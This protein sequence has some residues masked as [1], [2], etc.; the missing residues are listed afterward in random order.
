M[1]PSDMKKKDYWKAGA[2]LMVGLAVLS[3][4]M[5]VLGGLWFW[6]DLVPYYVRF[7][8]VKDLSTG[9]PVKYG[10]LDIGRVQDIKVDAKDP[11][12]IKV[13]LG[14]AADFPIYQGAVASISQKGLV[15]DYYVF[16]ELEDK[17][18]P[19][20]KPGAEIP[21][22]EGMSIQELA[23][24]AGELMAEIKPKIDEIVTNVNKVFSGEN[25]KNLS[26][27]LQKGPGFI[28]ETEKAIL[29]IQQDW[30]RLVREGVGVTDSLNAT[31]AGVDK[32]LG[33]VETELNATL[34]EIRKETEKA[35]RLTDD[36]HAY[37]DYDQEQV[38]G[39]LD[40]LGRTSRELKRL[41]QRLRERPWEVVRPPSE[42]A[43]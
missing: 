16:L 23:A 2:T 25:T 9:R 12:F 17:P 24:E 21:A 6:E 36:L 7:K 33:S 4:F 41:I 43:K 11:R 3:A 20:L 28:E 1:N 15:G 27:M 26:L 10:G 40:D 39:I 30:G 14:V 19:A 8:T 5:V 31:L 13:T 34:R 42:V 38:E 29:A 22:L 18:G 37:L 32:S 35:G